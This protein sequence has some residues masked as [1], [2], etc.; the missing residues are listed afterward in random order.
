MT[1]KALRRI[2]SLVFNAIKYMPFEPVMKL[3]NICCRVMLDSIG[4]SS[5]IC[6][7]VT[8]VNPSKVSIGDH[9]SV[10]ENTTIGGKGAVTIGDNVAIASHC[11]IVSDTHNF[12]ERGVLI[13]KQGVH[14][15]PVYIGSNVWIGT[16]VVI[17]GNVKIGDGAV[18]GAGSVVTKDI[19]ANA[20]AFGNPCRVARYR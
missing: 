16:H 15:E 7:A 2:S 19:P 17:L 3:R 6:D 5:N 11:H 10:H 1:R 9:V 4:K 18:V 12:S 14:E 8:F 13:K 20:V